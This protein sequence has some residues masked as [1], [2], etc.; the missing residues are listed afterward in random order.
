MKTACIAPP[1]GVC[2]KVARKS[3]KKVKPLAAF[4]FLCIGKLATM[5]TD[6]EAL[7]GAFFDDNPE[8]VF[9]KLNFSLDPVFIKDECPVCITKGEL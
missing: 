5:V 9:K 2:G 4:L 8:I 6:T 7:V 3:D 1:C